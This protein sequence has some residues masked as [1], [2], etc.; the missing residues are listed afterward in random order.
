MAALI[1]R[2]KRLATTITEALSRTNLVQ[3]WT[4]AIIAAVTVIGGGY[5]LA[6]VP[7]APRDIIGT[8][9]GMVIGYYFRASNGRKP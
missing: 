1:E 4:Q 6:F 8:L 7:S 3:D 2:E 5:V 9:V